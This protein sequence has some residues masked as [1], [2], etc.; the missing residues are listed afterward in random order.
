MAYSNSDTLPKSTAHAAAS[1]AIE[2]SWLVINC[3]KDAPLLPLSAPLLRRTQS[4]WNDGHGV[5]VEMLVV[6]Q[7]R[8]CLTGWDIEPLFDLARAKLTL[9]AQPSFET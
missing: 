7:Q 4:F 5:S 9:P 1:A 3:K 6:A 2:L 8:N